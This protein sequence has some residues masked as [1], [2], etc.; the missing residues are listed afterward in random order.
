MSSSAPSK[1]FSTALNTQIDPMINDLVTQGWHLW[2][3]ALPLDLCHALKSEAQL[4]KEAGLLKQAG[5]GR[6]TAHQ[7]NN[8]IR[9][10]QIK[11]LEGATEAQTQYLA[12]MALLQ[13]NLNRNLF[14]GLLEYECHFALYQ[15]GDF[16][17]THLDSFRGRANRMVTTVLYLNTDWQADM[18]GELVIYQEDHTRPVKLLPEIG[19]LVIFMSEQIPHEVLPTQSERVSIAGWFRCNNSLAGHIDP[20]N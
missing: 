18:G 15:K 17:K 2:P 6:K 8:N 1:A 14:L 13:Q 12:C 9:R 3:H 5:I 7:I 16:Y 10:D 4:H 19:Q 20:A 11:W